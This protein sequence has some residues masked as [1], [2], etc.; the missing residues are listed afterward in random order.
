[1]SAEDKALLKKLTG[2]ETRIWMAKLRRKIEEEA[3]AAAPIRT[4]NLRLR[5]ESRG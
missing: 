3:Q 2:P 1:M 4:G 5:G